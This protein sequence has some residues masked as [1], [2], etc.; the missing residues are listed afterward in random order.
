[1]GT[2]RLTGA[3][4]NDVFGR[5]VRSVWEECGIAMTASRHVTCRPTLRATP[6]VRAYHTDGSGVG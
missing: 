3:N 1:M 2:A 4:V 6:G 5:G